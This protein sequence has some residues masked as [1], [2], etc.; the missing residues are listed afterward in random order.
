MAST[1]SWIY[2]R[3]DRA[4]VL[5]MENDGYRAWRCGL[6]PRRHRHHDGLSSR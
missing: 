2:I 5:H 3:D 6:D 1:E 4:I